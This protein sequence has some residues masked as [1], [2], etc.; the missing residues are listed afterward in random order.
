ME[1]ENLSTKA[2]WEFT[3]GDTIYINRKSKDGLHSS[4]VL[5]KFGTLVRNTVHGT[6]VSTEDSYSTYR[7]KDNNISADLLK[8]ALFG[9]G[10]NEL[11]TCYHW[12]DNTGTCYKDIDYDVTEKT[13]EHPSFGIIGLSRRSSSAVTP[14]FGSNIQHQHTITLTI[15]TA[16]L[17][18]KLNNDWIHANKELIEVE[19]SGSQFAEL[20]TSFNIGDGVPCTIRDFNGQSYPH[21]PYESPVDIFQREFESKMKNLGLKC[22]SVMEDA[23]K[24]IKDKPT[25][26]KSDREFILKAIDNLMIEVSSNIPFVAQQFNKSMEKTISQAKN[27][28]ETFVTGRMM[29][30]GINVAKTNPDLFLGTKI[31]ESNKQID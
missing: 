30:L 21:P 20:I 12:F 1:V 8:C 17:D 26:S 11:N 15:K 16:S 27:E 13:I 24:I 14:L 25:I 31:E 29:A 6:I 19:L 5:C 22:S 10:K 2:I 28:V 7:D 18:R 3:E 9:K 4:F 23:F